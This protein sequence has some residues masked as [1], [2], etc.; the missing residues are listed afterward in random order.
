MSFRSQALRLL[1]GFVLLHAPAARAD[2]IEDFYRN[3]NVDLLVGFSAGGGYD[4]YA[5]LVGRHIGKHIPGAPNVV[6]KTMEGAGSTRLANWLYAVAPHDGS[7]FGTIARGVPL[8]PLFGNPGPQF[9]DDAAF[10]YIGSANDEVSVCGVLQ[11]AGFKTF[12]D[13]LDREMVVGGFGAGTESE[14][15]VKLMNAV[16]GTKVKLV[17]GYPGGNDVNLAMERGEVQGRC[18]WSWTGIR[19]QFWDRVKDGSLV[20]LIQNSLGKHADLPNVP[21]IMD[22]ATTDE[23]RQMLRLVLGPQRMGRPFMAPPALPA[24]RLSTL[25]RSFD[26]T[27]KDPEFLREAD[28]AQLEISPITGEEMQQIVT[29]LY[30]TPSAIVERTAQAIK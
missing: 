15:H 22:M 14:Q 6:V 11:R 24:D 26:A 12:A 17:K 3:R 19:A 1:C 16:F 20:I 5:R 9:K 7:V 8:D 2:A 29:N 27:M 28:K 4:V 13:L 30:K 18:G 23:Q 21:T 10:S 25:R